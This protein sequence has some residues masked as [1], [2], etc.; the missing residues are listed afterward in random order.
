MSDSLLHTPSAHVVKLSR[1]KLE[2]MYPDFVKRA[3]ALC[4]GG[5]K[6]N[7]AAIVLESKP[8][9]F[10]A[11]LAIM[12]GNSR[13]SQ[14]EQA[15]DK[16][17]EGL[18][19]VFDIASGLES[20]ETVAYRRKSKLWAASRLGLDELQNQLRP[21]IQEDRL[22]DFQSIMTHARQGERTWP[23]LDR[24][25]ALK[26]YKTSLR[27]GLAFTYGDRKDV[28]VTSLVEQIVT[29]AETM[30]AEARQQRAR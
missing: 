6:N 13:S 19:G 18:Q 20:R 26:K 21:L 4:P 8:T 22:N 16:L 25:N 23:E 30:C 29:L 15:I 9:G 5:S 3:E 7:I 2:T 11:A 10:A 24:Q 14:E 1:K 27:E 12:N 17:K 28:D